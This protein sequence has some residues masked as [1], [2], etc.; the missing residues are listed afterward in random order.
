MKKIIFI[1]IFLSLTSSSAPTMLENPVFFRGTFLKIEKSIKIRVCSPK[2]HNFCIIK[3]FDSTA[4]SFLVKH[5]NDKSYIMTSAHVC[6]TDF[7]KLKYLPGFKVSEEFYGLTDDMK[8]HAYHIEAVD[9]SADLCLVSTK[10]FK[11]MPFRIAKNNPNRGEKIFNIAAPLGF[12]EEK[13]I[14]LFEGYYIG[15]IHDRTVVTLPATGGSSGSPVLNQSGAVLGVVSSV[16]KNFHHVVILST[17][18]QIKNMIK[19]IK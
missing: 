7:G 3:E 19:T 14:P 10:R 6:V 4:S 8:R 5:R 12:F 9:Q 18:E 15:H 16:M 1:L 13:L 17:L 2:N 11:G